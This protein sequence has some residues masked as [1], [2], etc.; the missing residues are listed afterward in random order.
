MVTTSKP[1]RTHWRSAIEGA[2]R[3]IATQ[4]LSFPGATVKDS[5][6]LEAA[7]AMVGAH[8]PMLR[9]GQ[10]YDLALLSSADG[11][12]SLARAILCLAP[13]SRMSETDTADAVG[14]I[15]NMLAGTMKRRLSG[16]ISDLTLGLPIF[17][18]GYLTPSN[19]QSVLAFPT[20][21]GT[22]DTIVLIAG[23]RE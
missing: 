17:I 10:A 11:C 12:R 5:V 20:R 13:G 21:L 4:A 1:T 23:T 22:I 19:R 8:I 18:H 7:V 14:E 2:A 16:T 9:P 3:E 15:V 6:G